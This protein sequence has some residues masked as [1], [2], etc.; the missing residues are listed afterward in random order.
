MTTSFGFATTA[1]EVVAEIDLSGK[2]VV[3]T[4]GAGGVGVETAR[5]LASAGA[6]VTLAVRNMDAG[7][8]AVVDIVASTANRA[9]RVAHLDLAD[10][11]SVASFVSGWEGAL[12]ILVNNAAVM[13]LPE[14]SR[15][16][17]GWEQHLAT[18]HLGHFALTTGLHR[19]LA[20]A[21]GARVVMLSSSGHLLSPV[22]F[23]DLHYHFR[24]YD[25]RTAY[26]QSKT[27][28]ALFAVGASARWEQDGIFAN[29]VM[30]GAIR[31]NLQ[32][33]IK[34]ETKRS[35][36]IG[37]DYDQ[38]KPPANWKTPEQGAATTVFVASSP[39]LEGIGGR[40]FENCNEA[41]SVTDGAAHSYLAGVARYALE[42]SNADRLW[43]ESLRAVPRP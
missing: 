17:E 13:Q 23:D 15:S 36:G 41:E 22:V 8:A 9:V 32:R 16:A 35:W 37:D 40:Y 27:A 1:A 33:Y 38:A 20:A 42:P 28:N 4:G 11:A 26:G 10:L 39:V 25:P 7:R 31:T 3:V 12:D 21:G 19:P 43:E 14:L 30:P 5:A 29:A 2:R 6:E 18:N 34:E 24:P